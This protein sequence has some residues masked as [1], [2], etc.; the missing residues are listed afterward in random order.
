MESGEQQPTTEVWRGK[1]AKAFD[2]RRPTRRTERE[3]P[4]G[5]T[6]VYRPSITIST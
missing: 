2:A 5:I 4:I 3:V 6:L 1:E